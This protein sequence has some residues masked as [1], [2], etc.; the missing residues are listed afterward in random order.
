MLI[1]RSFEV[2]VLVCI[3]IK[4][5]IEEFDCIRASRMFSV[6]DFCIACFFVSCTPSGPST[7]LCVISNK[8]PFNFKRRVKMQSVESYEKRIPK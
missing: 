7:T 4:S 1:E 3:R 5:E 6:A 2:E 8:E